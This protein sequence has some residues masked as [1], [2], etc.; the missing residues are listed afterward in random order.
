MS[1]NQGNPNA[2]AADP[3]ATSP[4]KP[5]GW[6]GWAVFAGVILM[7]SG[8]FSGIQGIVALIG[9]NDYY[10]VTDGS[11]WLFD[12][13]GWGWWNLIVGVFLVLVALALFAGQTWARVIAI[14]L[15]VLS[16]IG[17]LLLVSAQPWWALIVIAIDVLAIYALTVH[18]HELADSER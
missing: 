11:L 13:N 3:R 15:L 18:G 5:S 16:A 17:Q 7:V 4:T 2:V 12:V 9:P 14:I 6:V 1:M 8:L 10:V